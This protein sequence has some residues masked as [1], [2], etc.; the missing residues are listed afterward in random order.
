MLTYISLSMLSVNN[1]VKYLPNISRYHLFTKTVRIMEVCL[2][3][4]LKCFEIYL[5]F[6][7][8][9]AIIIYLLSL[10][11]NLGTIFISL[12]LPQFP[13]SHRINLCVLYNYFFNF[14]LIHPLSHCKC[15][16]PQYNHILFLSILPKIGFIFN[17][18]QFTCIILSTWV[19]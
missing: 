9:N 8:K 18:F 11:S 6:T 12:N 5:K 2:H 1:W 14:A 7:W 4:F 19:F 3:W 17:P 16:N 10:L 15:H 13:L